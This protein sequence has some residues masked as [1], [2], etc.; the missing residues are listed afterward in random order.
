MEI[1]IRNLGVISSAQFDL[2]P[3]TIFVGP[4]N[5]GK[6][7]AAYALSMIFGPYG[8]RKYTDD[9]SNKKAP[10]VYPDLDKVNHQLLSEGSA[11]LDIVDFATKHGVDYFNNVAKHARKS[12]GDYLSTQRVNFENM[13]I[14][15][16]LTDDIN[17]LLRKIRDS[18]ISTKLSIRPKTKKSLLNAVKEPGDPW[19]YYYTEGKVAER[20]P[21]KVVNKFLAELAFVTLHRSLYYNAFPL[22]PERTT[23]STIPFEI[24]KEPLRLTVKE[25]ETE[26]YTTGALRF[27]VP[28]NT[29]MS[30][31]SRAYRTSLS[32]RKE[33]AREDKSIRRYMKLAQILE[34]RVL[35]GILDFSVPELDPRREIL[36]QPSKNVRL[37]MPV[38]S[39]M[40][41][42]L[43]SLVLYLRYVA[44]ANELLIIDEPEMNL[45][46]EAQAYLI[47][48][49]A[50]LIDAGLHI[51]VTTHSSYIVDHLANLMKA[52]EIDDKK[53][54]QRKFYMKRIEAFIPRG[55][56]SVYLF[57]GGT[58]KNIL[59]KD[60][61]IDWGTFGKVS[62]RISQ[63]YY[64]L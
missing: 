45:H 57:K 30:M 49:L 38:V 17:R 60:G 27:S 20:L 22:P 23:I 52:A 53:S 56:V 7:W 6:T 2:K 35:G 3:L 15:L 33:R 8:W 10:G 29:F 36:F 34:E 43:S 24:G 37:D 26:T 41:K 61:L 11:R 54:I 21:L 47:E 19:I 59:K 18:S 48:F 1:A 63:I 44:R 40:V 64:D 9:H 55:K 42:E 4:N 50:M 28:V 51:L 25:D 58:A 32:K 13:E 62:D 14:H 5:S 16:D 39:S 31:L 46:P 12:I